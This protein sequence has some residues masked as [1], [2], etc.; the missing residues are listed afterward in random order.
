M[1]PQAIYAS[2]ASSPKPR[3]TGT[4]Q[5]AFT[6]MEL[7]V[8]IGIIAILAAL[9]LPSLSHAKGRAQGVV[10]LNNSKQLMTAMALYTADNHDF[11]PP[12]P[13][14]GNLLP[15]YNWCAGHAG[16][17]NPEEF[18][19]DVILDPN[20]S[21][22]ISHLSGNGS[23]FR[24]PS[25]HRQ[26]LYQGVNPALL[27]KTVPV[28]RT[29]SMNQAVGTIDPTYD[30][31]GFGGPHHGVPNLSVN[32]PWLDNSGNHSRNSPW[33]TFGKIT[34]SGTPGP[35][36]LWVLMDENIQGLND[37][38]FAFGME[39]P[40]WVDLPGLHHNGG[41]SVAF[42]DGHSET[43]RWRY[44]AHAPGR[45]TDLLD[46]QDWLWMWARTSANVSGAVTP[47]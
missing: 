47:P 5:A 39:V 23:V 4:V 1:S 32:G 28:A 41:C 34:D 46:H 21:L 6:L 38:A 45:V 22:L 20:R 40:E 2:R 36:M 16:I 35:S 19:P 24:C 31:T 33:R 17:G 30:V 7:L 37:A 44:R 18:N 13:D 3:S 42:A 9:L 27:G 26:G 8:V 43:H 12:N 29:F 11:F 14:D 10:C 25:D 15:G